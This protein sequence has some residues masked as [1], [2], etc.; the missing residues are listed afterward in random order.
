MNSIGIGG[1]AVVQG[2][3]L[4]QDDT[5]AIAMKNDNTDEVEVI[6]DKHKGILG[7]GIFGKIP[8][9]RGAFKLIDDLL[10]GSEVVTRSAEFYEE[11]EQERMADSGKSKRGGDIVFAIVFIFA[12]A[13]SF[14]AFV[15]APYKVTEYV[16]KRF[17]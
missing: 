8:I 5:Y 7:T 2:V 13:L 1:Q 11:K 12:L 6:Y 17:L 14:A 15:F 16:G 9:I 3:M 4:K 10:L